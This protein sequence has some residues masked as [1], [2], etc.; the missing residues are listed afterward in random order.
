M[1]KEI[2]NINIDTKSY[3]LIYDGMCFDT[4]PNLPT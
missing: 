1:I 3:V 4:F 2:T